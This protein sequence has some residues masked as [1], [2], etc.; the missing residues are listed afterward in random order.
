MKFEI[1]KPGQYTSSRWSGG[2]TTELYIYPY[3]SNLQNLDFQF[4]ISTATVEIEESTFTVFP[5]VKRIMLPLQ[6]EMT[7]MHD[8]NNPIHLKP[9]EQD[10][11]LG[12]SITKCVGKVIDF[13]L[14]TR[15]NTTGKI[16]VIQLQPGEQISVILENS[17]IYCFT[18]QAQIDNQH[19][20]TNETLV[21]FSEAA[22]VYNL[23][24]LAQSVLLKVDLIVKI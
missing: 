13:N 11:F 2:T 16:E 20:K 24:A 22:Q 4:R 12:D 9:F 23:K 1:K 3:G 18:G 6:G 15:G 5:G 17:V 14:M 7:L 8:E 21:Y 19:F 10:S